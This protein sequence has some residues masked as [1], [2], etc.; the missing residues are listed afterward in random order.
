MSQTDALLALLS[1]GQDHST[2]EIA[3]KV[4]GGSH[5]GCARIGARI[6]D[7]KRRGYN[8]VGRKHPVIKAAY[9]YRLVTEAQGRMFA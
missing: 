8:I 7:L 4:Y 9:I 1:D 6:Y 3:E 2:Y 5:L